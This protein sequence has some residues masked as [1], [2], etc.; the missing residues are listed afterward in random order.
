MVLHSGYSGTENALKAS[1]EVHSDLLA[2]SRL[3]PRVG[4]LSFVGLGGVLVRGGGGG[5]GGCG[6]DAWGDG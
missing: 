2:S 1:L 4:N 3:A 5:T 6:A